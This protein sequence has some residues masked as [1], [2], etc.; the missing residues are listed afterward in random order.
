MTISIFNGRALSNQTRGLHCGGHTPTGQNTIGFVTIA[1]TGDAVDF[2]DISYGAPWGLSVCASPT[3]GFMYGGQQ[4]P[5][6]TNH[7]E[8]VTIATTGNTQEFGDLTHAES[9]GVG[10]NNSTRGVNMGGASGTND[11]VID[12]FNLASAG[13]AVNFGDLT[14]GR[15]VVASMAS[16]IRGLCAGGRDDTP[17]NNTQ[18]D[19]IDYITFATQGDAVDFGNMLAGAKAPAGLSNAHGGL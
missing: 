1:S 12:Y 3:R 13:N 8:Y 17:S 9:N 15:Y 19:I 14:D 7:I 11:S 2:G 16:S 6:E 10:C 18:S 4:S 5:A